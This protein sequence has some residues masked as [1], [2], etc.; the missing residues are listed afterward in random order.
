MVSAKKVKKNVDNINTRLNLVVKSGLLYH[1]SILYLIWNMLLDS[2]L[3]MAV[4]Y[5]HFEVVKELLKYKDIDVNQPARFDMTPLMLAAYFNHLEIAELLL[6]HPK[7]QVNL[8]AATAQREE[9]GDTSLT[10]AC[11]KNHPKM[12]ELHLQ[13]ARQALDPENLNQAMK[14]SKDMNLLEIT[15]V[16]QASFQESLIAIQTTTKSKLPALLPDI[17]INPTFK[18]GISDS[19][20]QQGE[21]EKSAKLGKK[22]V[23]TE[24]DSSNSKKLRSQKPS[25]YETLAEWDQI[26]SEKRE[27][28]DNNILSEES[29]TDLE[30]EERRDNKSVNEGIKCAI[31]LAASNFGIKHPKLHPPLLNILNEI[32]LTLAEQILKSTLQKRERKRCREEMKKQGIERSPVKKLINL[33]DIDFMNTLQD[34]NLLHYLPENSENMSLP[35]IAVHPQFI[36]EENLSNEVQD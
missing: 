11:K 34:H 21:K 23:E 26:E 14:I 5:G 18:G 17:D 30:Q 6:R 7:I 15:K 1:P 25:E 8:R 35:K 27:D 29:S 16:L 22:G 28:Q 32:G 13:L 31:H 20:E 24:K 33:Q 9:M 19:K 10:F 2:P 4:G 3:I 12:V 36:Q